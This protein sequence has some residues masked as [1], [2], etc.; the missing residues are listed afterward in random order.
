MNDKNHK[1]L[2]KYARKLA[3]RMGLSDWAIEIMRDPAEGGYAEVT[4]VDGTLQAQ[5]AVCNDFFHLTPHSQR[6]YMVHELLHCSFPAEPPAE[7]EVLLDS[8]VYMIFEANFRR[9]VERGVDR[10]A[11]VL[12][13]YLPT[14]G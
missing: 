5:I 9:E 11:E 10:T 8:E 3:R 14:M 1:R 4:I 6:Y 13:Q 12:A 7:L 2:T